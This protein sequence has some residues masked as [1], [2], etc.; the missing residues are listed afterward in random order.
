MSK[1]LNFLVMMLL[2]ILLSINQAWG[3][4]ETVTLD[5]AGTSKWTNNVVT[6]SGVTMTITKGSLT[7]NASQTRLSSGAA[8]TITAPSGKKVVSAQITTNSTS[9]YVDPLKSTSSTY[10]GS[11]C[12]VS[13]TTATITV[14]SGY[15]SIVCTNLGGAIRVTSCKVTIDDASCTAPGT[16]LSVTSAATATVGTPLSLTTTGGNG[17]T[18][19][20]SV[21]NG[22]GSATVSGSMLTPVTA[23]TI[24]VKA[25]Q[26]QSGTTCEQDAE[27]TVTIS[28]QVASFTF[29][30]DYVETTT[31]YVGDQYTLPS[32]TSAE[33]GDKTFVGWSTT[34]ITETSPTKPTSNYYDKGS[35]V[36]LVSDNSFYAVFATESAGAS[37]SY[38][39]T[40]NYSDLTTTS[41]ANNNKSHDVTATCTTDGSKKLTIAYT[42]NQVMQSSSKLQFQKDNGCLYNTTDL[43]SITSVTLASGATALTTFYGTSSH[44]TSGPSVGS[45]NGYFTVVQTGATGSVSSITVNFTKGGSTYT[46]D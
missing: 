13:G 2:G 20:W 16:A 42:T 46:D 4:T 8:F 22:T 14:S 6:K 27:Q 23:G 29:S 10:T 17:G 32:T 31:Y 15:S 28:K 1:K 40:I 21:T 26:D 38:S 44:P 33:C 9:T 11:T 35:K 37:I 24:T 19:T 5:I 36:T 39:F 34:P 12:T 25:H 45:G 30:D 41:Y 7:N 43:G 3:A 18:V